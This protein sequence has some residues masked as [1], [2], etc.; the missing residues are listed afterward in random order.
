MN[1]DTNLI[2]EAYKKRLVKESQDQNY[3]PSLEEIKAYLTKSYKDDEVR[4]SHPEL[5]KKRMTGVD[6]RA[7]TIEELIKAHKD[8]VD[9]WN[10]DPANSDREP[11]TVWGSIY[12]E[13][14]D[15]SKDLNGFR[16]RT[17]FEQTPIISLADSLLNV[18]EDLREEREKAAKE[19]AR[20]KSH[21]ETLY[22][23][24]QK[25]DADVVKLVNDH[26]EEAVSNIATIIDR[27]LI[28]S[29]DN[30]GDGFI[31]QVAHMVMNTI[32]NDRE[33]KL[34]RQE[35]D[36]LNKELHGMYLA[37]KKNK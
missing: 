29:V 4:Y 14:S 16:S 11:Y 12:G 15:A 1:N 31:S 27:E 20:V 23:N 5:L 34:D 10:S 35:R 7:A 2:F 21:A 30:A 6:K 17:S 9:K 26:A 3:V 19:D 18:F 36:A 37:S 32:H 24:P 8:W 33:I 13:F 28:K 22:S 25:L